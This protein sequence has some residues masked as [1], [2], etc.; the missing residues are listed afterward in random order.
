[1]YAVPP[2]ARVERDTSY[3]LFTSDGVVEHG[4]LRGVPL[5]G[6]LDSRGSSS[7]SDCNDGTTNTIMVVEAD[8]DRAV[9]WVK[10]QDLKFDPANPK[11]G[12]GH[13]RSGGFLVVMADG[14]V[15]FIPNSM[16]DETLRRL[17]LRDDREPVGFDD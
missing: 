3:L 14:A 11:A 10:P 16:D 15:R 5:F 17:V 1:V 9:L 8:R 13:V 6:S 7:L 4:T 12:L 2:A